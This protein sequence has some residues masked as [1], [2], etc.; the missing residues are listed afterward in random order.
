M[1]Y[2][3]PAI[4]TEL[5]KRIETG[6]YTDRLPT[7]EELAASFG[8][9][10]KTIHKALGKL[11]E[12]GLIE[13][14][15]RSGTRICRNAPPDRHLIEVLFEGF[16]AIFS[17]PFWNEIWSGMTEVL[18]AEGFR[19]VLHML[20]TDPET[21][22]LRLENFS[23]TPSA[24]K[25]ILGIGEKRLFDL[26]TAAGTPFIAGCDRINDPRIPQITFDF[27]RGISEAV[28]HLYENGARKIA[29]V[30]QC[31][32]YISLGYLHKFESYLSAIQHYSPINPALIGEAAPLPGAGAEAVR[33]ILKTGERPDGMIAAYD[34]QLPEILE[35]LR[36]NALTIPVVGCDGLPLPGLPPQRPEILVP[37]KKC[38]ELLARELITGIRSR[39]TPASKTLNAVFYH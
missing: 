33:T 24:G 15:R 9:N 3:Q 31:R 20:R 17:H 36:R 21:G 6:E 35:E 39:R 18:L 7:S 10:I 32:N 1:E 19:P 29:F 4:M 34:H 25:I 38:G 16:A 30:G 5:K 22:I 14:K 12:A 27:R 13:R 26:V 11:V 37:R 8:V 28:T 2:K 23:M